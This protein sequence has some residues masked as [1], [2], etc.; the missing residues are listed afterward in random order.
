MRLFGEH[1]ADAQQGVQGRVLGGLVEGESSR[2]VEGWLLDR[3]TGQRL[4]VYRGDDGRLLANPRQGEGPPAAII[5][6][7]KAG[8]Y[9]VGLLLERLGYR[10]S[11]LHVSQTFLTDYRAMSIAQK[12]RPAFEERNYALPIGASAQ[13]IGDGQFLVGHLRAE[14][15]ARRALAG[16]KKVFLYRDLVDATISH[17]RF[18]VDT[19]RAPPDAAWAAMEPS[20]AQLL[21]FLEHLGD[22]LFNRA[23]RPLMGWLDDAEVFAISFEELSGDRGLE[24]RAARLR[25]LTDFLGVGENP[26]QLL[27]SQVMGRQTKTLSSGRTEAQPYLDDATRQALRDL[28]VNALHDRLGYPQV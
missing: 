19:G 23:Y 11:E 15:D 1:P 25:E 3:G 20:P 16:F 8:T 12:R 24:H 9:M 14:D 26:E 13:L 10:D 4:R 18:V 17:L 7:P 27:A 28:G 5:S 2:A 22:Y 6:I 21:G